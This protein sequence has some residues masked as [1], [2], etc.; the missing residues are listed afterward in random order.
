MNQ[1]TVAKGS[2]TTQ[3]PQ[4]DA[5]R[6]LY[7]GIL[8]TFIFGISQYL[9]GQFWL[10]HAMLALALVAYV[11]Q[12]PAVASGWAFALYGLACGVVGVSFTLG[13]SWP[14]GLVGVVF[15]VLLA[16]YGLRHPKGQNSVS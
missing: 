10:G 4:R 6:V 16:D 14:L 13:L 8:I 12:T 7:G 2:G 11:V 3:K 15:V 5:P 1:E 9:W